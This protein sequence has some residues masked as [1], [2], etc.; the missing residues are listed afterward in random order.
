MG[1]YDDYGRGWAARDEEVAELRQALRIFVGCAYPVA[2]EIN[3]RGHAWRPEASLDYALEE[4]RK[5][6]GMNEQLKETP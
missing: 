1:E 4:A 5:A 3:P 6:L 2:T